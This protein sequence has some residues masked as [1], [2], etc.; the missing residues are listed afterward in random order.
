[1]SKS[2]AAIE[3]H[4]ALAAGTLKTFVG[5]LAAGVG[6][7]ALASL[8]GAF[9]K[10]KETISE[11]DEIATNAKQT[12]L[13]PETYQA[14]G[15]AAKQA[16]VE[17]ESF[18]SALTI[19][20]KNAGL[21]EHGTGA[22]YAGLKNL[23]P[24]LLQ[25]IINAKDQEERLKLV[26]DAMAQTTDATQKA[27]LAAVVFGKGGVEM[28][29]FLDQGRASIDAMKKSARDLGIIIPDDLLQ[30][31]GELDDKLDVLAKVTHVQLGEAL[32]NLAPLLVDAAAGFAN[33]SKEINN[34]SA[35]VDKFIN[36]PSW[37]SFNELLVALGSAPIR[38]G[39]VL[40]RLAKGNLVAPGSADVSE[41]TKGI[42]FL[43]QK[44]AELKA[45]AEQGANVKVEIDDAT[46]SLNDLKAR[47]LEVQGVGVSAANEISAGFAEAFRA[48][49][50]ASM[51]ALASMR[52]TTTGA[53]PNVTRYGGDPNSITLPGK[54]APVVQNNANSS[55]VNVT[56]YS[57][58]TADNTSTTADNVSKL[59]RNTKGYL[60]DLSNDMG[61]Y[62][63]QQVQQ[64]QIT[65]SKLS[66]VVRGNIGGLSSSILAA[67]VAGG[68]PGKAGGIGPGAYAFG[69]A[70]DPS[71]GSYISSWG[72]GSVERPSLQ[73]PST[74]SDG[75][76]NTDVSVAQPGNSF[77]LNYHAAAG[78]STDTA[79]QRA[80][81]MYDEL[82]NA[83]AS[84]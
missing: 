50:N 52:G 49:E 39:S 47:L 63:Q 55:G 44:L 57:S 75:S 9:D 10:L 3:K 73:F 21:A 42:D 76:S 8:G 14:L 66:D 22:L 72:V 79:K 69:D 34:G 64:E 24:Q 37:A 32:I 40:D 81:E 45:Q 1:M 68:G 48:A 12:G 27:A 78:E 29:R 15:F 82:I 36:D 17:Q 71:I 62:S 35:A 4:T 46:S 74:A 30:R 13:K 56:K 5:G 20:A 53:L 54:G 38:E 23:N 26:A 33:L 28:A 6:L 11:Y 2:I 19:F 18:N 43:E 16:N 58:E 84:A 25:N 51:E 41:L 80:R 59:D 7:T 67:L 60:R 61:Q 31:A 65:I 83:A 70:F 77:T